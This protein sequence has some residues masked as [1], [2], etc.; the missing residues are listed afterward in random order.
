MEKKLIEIR[1]KKDGSFTFEAKE[2]FSGTSCIEK[3]KE[4]EMVLSNGQ[5]GQTTT[6]SEYYDDDPGINTNLNLKFK[7]EWRERK[8]KNFIFFNK[9]ISNEYNKLRSSL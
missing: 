3:T 2:G 7:N 4:L 5:E 9:D 8:K 1:V 6:K